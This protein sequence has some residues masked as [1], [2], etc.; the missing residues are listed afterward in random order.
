MTTTTAGTPPTGSWYPRAL[1]AV[2]LVLTVVNLV[3]LVVTPQANAT[4]LLFG[5]L[6]TGLAAQVTTVVHVLFFAWLTWGC[7][8]HRAAMV[9]AVMAYCIYVAASLW[10]WTARYGG[11]FAEAPQAAI[12]VNAVVTL[13]LLALCR[14]TFAR[15]HAFD[16]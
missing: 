2:A 8:T 13:C 15:R 7:F 3:D 5:H 12:L 1:G 16:R 11:Q 6:F 4:Q 9:W 10:I 14:A